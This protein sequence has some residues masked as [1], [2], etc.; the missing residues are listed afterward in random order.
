M[1]NIVSATCFVHSHGEMFLY[2]ISL[3][4]LDIVLILFIF[5]ILPPCLY[6]EIKQP[7]ASRRSK[8]QRSI[9]VGVA[10]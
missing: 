7:Q 1:E 3:D 10:L 9:V 4:V 5:Y 8:G 2:K 6:L